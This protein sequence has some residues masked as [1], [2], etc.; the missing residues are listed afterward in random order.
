VDGLNWTC[1][2]C[3]CYLPPNNPKTAIDVWSKLR[4]NRIGHDALRKCVTLGGEMMRAALIEEAARQLKLLEEFPGSISASFSHNATGRMELLQNMVMD[5]VSMLCGQRVTLPQ[6]VEE[7]VFTLRNGQWDEM[8]E[9][10]PQLAKLVKYF[11]DHS[12]ISSDDANLLIHEFRRL[13][14]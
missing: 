12:L 1:I 9:K 8:L 4:N 13:R 10:I 6:A 2:D 5:S 3:S 11:E 7:L 14:R